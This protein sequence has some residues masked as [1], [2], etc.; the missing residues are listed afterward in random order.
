[1]VKHAANIYVVKIQEVI[2]IMIP[3]H[4]SHGYD[5]V[6]CVI[7]IIVRDRVQGLYAF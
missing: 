5:D 6:L 3:L 4:N 7:Y 2:I 1:M